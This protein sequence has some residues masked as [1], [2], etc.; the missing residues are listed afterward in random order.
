MQKTD[1][2]QTTPGSTCLFSRQ[3]KL[4]AVTI[5]ALVLLMIS[6]YAWSVYQDW[7]GRER[8]AEIQ[9]AYYRLPGGDG[10]CILRGQLNELRIVPLSILREMGSTQVTE[11]NP[12]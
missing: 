7:D 11:K 8:C 6:L 12:P 1:T 4:L 5:V 2:K 3:R 9:S 10:I